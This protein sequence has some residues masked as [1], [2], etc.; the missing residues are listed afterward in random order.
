[1]DKK[2]IGAFVLIGVVLLGWLYW[3]SEQQKKVQPVKPPVTQTD[4]TTK[5]SADTGSIKNI[6]VKDSVKTKDT[7]QKAANDSLSIEKYSSE[8]GNAF[9]KHAVQ[10]DKDNNITGQKNIVI[11][12]DLVIMEFSNYGGTLTKF[13]TKKFNTYD[14][15]PVQLVDWKKG[16]ELHIIFTSKDGK[17]IDTKDLVFSSAYQPW[18]SINLNDNAEYKLEYLLNIDSAKT[19]QIKII[20]TFKKDSYEFDVNYELVNSIAYISDAKY[21]LV[22]GSSLNLTEGRSDVE[23]SYE[24]AYAYLGGELEDIDATDFEK[25]TVGD[26][27]GNT[28]YVASRNKYFGVFLIPTSRKGDG[29]YLEGIN[30]HLKDAGQRKEYS[31][32]VKMDIKNDKVNNDKFII[33][34]SPI[35]YNILKSYNME[36]QLVQ[37]FALDFI[38]RPIAQWVIMP[39]FNFLHTFIPNFGF[40][41]IVFALILKIVLNPLTKKQ[42]DSMKRLGQLSPK[43]TAIRE[44]YKDDPV[45]MNEQIMKLYKEEKINPMGGCLPM[46]LQLPILYA[47]FGVFN[48]TI[49]LRQQPFILWIHD[50]STPDVIFNLPFKIPIFGID[51]V[52]GLATL[53]GITMFIQQKMTITDPKQ[54]AMVY[55]MPI[56]LTLLFFSFP[57]GLNLYYFT[58]NLLSII[59]QWY[60]T[61]L[62]AKKEGSVEVIQDKPKRKSF[63]EIKDE[64][65]SKKKK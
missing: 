35:D 30:T 17:M 24:K 6:P 54:K 28:D 33:L 56:M 12:N 64:L 65:T 15:H 45:K 44:K 10:Y 43:M 2:T 53:M 36:L 57:A 50:L 58:F 60:E 20:Y 23:A 47:L 5:T 18:D 21:Q 61:K 3:T 8:F 26:Y 48:S 49:E 59:Q 37:S 14:G 32:A 11:Q 38:V 34:L 51:Q 13:I 16:K 39:L 55:I 31:I 42:M 52:S 40:V 9:Y 4:T 46:L 22:W 29:A 62:K 1:M 27:N 19:Q 63:Q 7:T 41:I 25:E